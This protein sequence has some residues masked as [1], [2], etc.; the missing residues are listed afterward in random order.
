GRGQSGYIWSAL[1]AIDHIRNT[2]LWDE[3]VVSPVQFIPDALSGNLPAVSWIVIG[4][5]NSEHPPASTCA[6]ENWT[7]RQINAVMQGPSWNETAIFLTW[8]DF[9]G[10]Y[11][12]VPPP[13]VD[14]FGF[15]PRVPLIVIS[16]FAKPGLI[17]HTVYEFSSLLKFVEQKFSLAPMTERHMR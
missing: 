15:G 8:D 7:V 13:M 14:N 4:S 9:G 5:G 3:K 2:A 10:F 17:S 12:H 6:G 16:P 11:D 1:D